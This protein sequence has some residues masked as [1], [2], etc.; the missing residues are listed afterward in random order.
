M[1]FPVILCGGSGTRLWPLSRKLYP[2]QFLKL[3]GGRTLLQQTMTRL[4]SIPDVNRPVI[5]CNEEHRFLAAEQLRE[6]GIVPEAIILEPAGKNTAPAVA[7]AA[8]YLAQKTDGDPAMLVLPAD[9]L[10]KNS[11]KF[12]EAVIAGTELTARGKLVTFGIV[13]TSPE[14][15]Y[16]YIRRGEVYT[17][18]AVRGTDIHEIAEFVEKPDRQTAM[19]YL[20]DGSYSWNSGMFMFT[21]SSY[22]S[23][24]AGNRKSI[25]EQ[26]E[27]AM[28]ERS[29]DLDFIRPDRDA[30]ATC[31][32]DSIDYAVMEH[33]D[34][35]I[36]IPVDMGWSDIGSWA[37]LLEEGKQD[38][39]GNVLSGDALVHDTRDSL[40]YA[41]ERLVTA[42]G[43][44]G[45]VIVETGDAV[46]VADRNRVQDVRT[47]VKELE[48]AGRHETDLH[49]MVYRPWG[50]YKT[51][52]TGDRFQVKLITV[53]PGATLSLQMHHHRAEHWIVVRG[54]AKITKENETFILHED[55]STYIPL[56]TTHSL[57]NPGVI[58]LELVEVQ[59]GSY[60]GED[61][62][63]RFQDS[64]GRA[65]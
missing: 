60:L 8:M 44:T 57:E 10:V 25:Y 3:T 52:M 28:A 18:L 27:K 43:M 33:T 31:P 23:E 35:G 36:V 26:C 16:G 40:I 41:T 1:L 29:S 24:L 50:S 47:I 5:V 12:T 54:T 45:T 14:T 58:P 38:D 2:K 55:Q 37:A 61:D 7:L 11:E 46:L 30:F 42:V 51:I 20:N 9:H 63:I 64:Y 19:S 22:L 32:D 59:S 65:G 39:D 56:G 4:D 21:A 34:N 53:K 62:I 13:P 48:T 17:D 15:G 49:L 6:A